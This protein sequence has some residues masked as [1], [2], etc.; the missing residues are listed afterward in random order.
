MIS[1]QWHFLYVTN[2]DER[3]IIYFIS[4]MTLW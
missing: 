3:K 1:T 4:Q 2:I